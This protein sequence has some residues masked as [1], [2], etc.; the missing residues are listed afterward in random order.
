MFCTLWC[1]VYTF[2]EAGMHFRFKVTSHKATFFTVMCYV[3]NS[4]TSILS[5]MIYFASTTR[6]EGSGDHSEFRIQSSRKGR[7]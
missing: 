7:K 1:L 3:S 4:K 5:H 2:M 6:I